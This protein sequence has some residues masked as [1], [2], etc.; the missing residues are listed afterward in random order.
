M[1]KVCLVTD[2]LCDANGVSR[3]IQDIARVALRKNYEFSVICPTKKSYCTKAKNLKIITPLISFPMP[4]YHELDLVVPPF[5]K[6][7]KEIK[8]LQ[9]DILHIATPGF[10]GLVTLMIAKRLKIPVTGTYH[11][12]FPAYIYSNTKS[13]MAKSITTKYMKYFYG[14]FKAI[15]IRS[16]VYRDKIKETLGFTDENIFT[17]PPGIYSERFDPKFRNREYWNSIGLDAEYKILL[18]VGRVSK[19]KNIEFLIELWQTLLNRG[20]VQSKN[21]HLIL[22]GSGKLSEDKVYQKISN[23]H[24]LGH[25][26]GDELSTIYASSDLFIF[27]S[28]TDTLGQVVIEAFSSGLPALVTDEGGPKTIVGD[29]GLCGFSF[30]IDKPYL[31]IESIETLL[32]NSKQLEDMSQNC[33]DKASKM[34]IEDSF[35]YFW[36]QTVLLID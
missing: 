21:L 7:Y 31:W 5:L 14:S 22:V 36:K 13:K 32:Q 33:R 4:F 20:I 19:E 2:T 11:T 8:I 23:L 30:S 1:P 12:D 3:F 27:P 9:P 26:E 24:F 17:I 34:H 15:F 6:L 10:V 35:D 28:T 29:A 25:K 18:Y 16:E